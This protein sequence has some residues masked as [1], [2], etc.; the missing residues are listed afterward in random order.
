MDTLDLQAITEMNAASSGAQA[1]VESVP[2][3]SVAQNVKQSFDQ[4]LQQS[5]VFPHPDVNAPRPQSAWEQFQ[6]QQVI[7]NNPTDNEAFPAMA[8]QDMFTP[9][10]VSTFLGNQIAP[11]KGYTPY[12]D[13]KSWAELTKGIPE[14]WHSEFYNAFSPE[15][16]QYIKQRLIQKQD[17]LQKLA[18][19]DTTGNVVR[20]G[21]GILNPEM[22]A[23]GFLTGGAADLAR[24]AKTGVSVS[25][26]VKLAQEANMTREAFVAEQAAKSAE[27][28][29]T[30]DHGTGMFTPTTAAETATKD[31]A[32]SAQEATAADAVA[33]AH[34]ASGSLEGALGAGAI[35]GGHEKLRQA[36]NFEDNNAQVFES[37]LMAMAFSAPF[38]GLRA[39]EMD[40]VYKAAG[41]ERDTLHVLAK[42]EA[43]PQ[44]E[45]SEAEQVLLAHYNQAK[46]AAVENQGG[47]IDSGT[48]GAAQHQP[49]ANPNDPTFMTGDEGKVSGWF[50]RRGILQDL[51]AMFNLQPN[52]TLRSMAYDLIKDPIG[53]SK[54]VAQGE[55]ASEIKKRYQRTLG[56]EFHTIGNQAFKDVAKAEGWSLLDR[57][58]NHHKFFDDITRLKS[59]DT[60]VYNEYS[61]EAKAHF[62]K[63]VAAQQKVYDHLLA[64]AKAH[65]LEGAEG[66]QQDANYVNRMW[67][68]TRIRELMNK[69]SPEEVYQFLA[70]NMSAKMKKAFSPEDAKKFIHTVMKLEYSHVQTEMNL[71]ARDVDTLRGE[72]QGLLDKH[73][74]R[75]L[76]D[77]AVEHY[78]KT[79]MEDTNSA[80]E[81]DSGRPANL[82][83]RLPIDETY[84][85]KMKDGSTLRT[86]DFFEN[87]SRLLVDRYLNTM[88][89]HAALAK[90]G[91][92]SRA[93]FVQRLA[94][95]EA[96]HADNLLTRSPQEFEKSSQAMRDIYNEITGKP[97]SH[98]TFSA[99][100]R[101]LN[102]YRA[103]TRASLLGQLGIVAAGEIKN[104]IGLMTFRSL[105]KQVP[106]LNKFFESL[107]SGH[108]P[109][110]E[111]QK[112]IN[113]VWGFG[114]ERAMAYA[115]QH[116]VTDFTYDKELSR[117]ENIANSA[118]H[119]ADIV[120][121]NG[122]FTSFTREA[123]AAMEIQ[124]LADFA[125]GHTEL[126]AS[127]RERLVHNG[128]SDHAIDPML[129]NLK[130]FANM[131][132]ETIKSVDYEAWSQHDPDSFNDF[133]L[134]V[135][136]GVRDAIQ[137]HDLG[138]LPL[139]TKTPIG[140]IFAELRTF[141]L[142]AHSKQFLKGLHYK[143]ATTYMQWTYAFT[144]E[145]M[146]YALQSA[147]NY[148]HDPETLKKRLAPEHLVAA[149][150]TRMGVL[151]IMPMVVDTPYAMFTGH[152]LLGQYTSNT[153]SRNLLS[154]PSLALANKQLGAVQTI[155]QAVSPWS[156][157]T[158]TKQDVQNAFQALPLSNTW[159]VRNLIDM[160]SSEFPKTDPL[161]H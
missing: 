12:A 6:E 26:A 56:G 124:R 117:F 91:Y 133:R 114:Q 112:M 128:V 28:G 150:V 151:G 30:F 27:Y 158:T 153:G 5:T 78:I 51:Y 66:I 40:R 74:N 15:H 127:L 50:G 92:T 98:Q 69:H 90:A 121:G 134:V 97:T 131:D 107:R 41:V 146:T 58:K 43:N 100:E 138:E 147:I 76:D 145:M 93:S 61:A 135:E 71:V 53:N 81:V 111:M 44:V 49:I 57:F 157:T 73:G 22:I 86:R 95:A 23:A 115:R 129:E 104:A 101:G 116:E 72:L 159:G 142:A 132:G 110:G 18:G 143:D 105:S 77:S 14:E 144:G 140:K 36:F 109:D 11:V 82:K 65:G 87:D 122:H 63:A 84:A 31:A 39:H 80:K 118:S 42:L 4:K 99:T 59:G 123:S 3:P 34:S 47:F 55:T 130:K 137:D 64:E 1:P 152:S 75:V 126:T 38:L 139:W 17:D 19:L 20:F 7:K 125:N 149:A 156:D 60:S 70:D 62:D 48:V 13:P 52:Q 83:Y 161:R 37:G 32:I 113:S 136:R 103:L 102:A 141:M 33:K 94:E 155:G 108:V 96:E 85:M 25:R 79:V 46:N 88:G 120:S 160:T 54:S 24:F 119:V 8:R 16:A 29:T 2:S 35:F 68:Q 67:N 106:S 45:L 89:G 9:G 154:T 148:A 21:F 10:L